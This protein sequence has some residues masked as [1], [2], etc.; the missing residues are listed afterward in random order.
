MSL[1][2][3]EIMNLSA[4]VALMADQVNYHVSPFSKSMFD[5]LKKML[6]WPNDKVLP[7]L[8]SIR[9]LFL[10]HAACETLLDAFLNDPSWC[11]LVFNHVLEGAHFHLTFGIRIVANLLARKKR[12]GF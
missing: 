5:L 12:Y 9:I 8:D 2:D 10:H 1:N 7:V 3:D 11:G 6:T 4:L